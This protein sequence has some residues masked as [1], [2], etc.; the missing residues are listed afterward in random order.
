MP[1]KG[2][3]AGGGGKP[4]GKPA[5]PKMK[6]VYWDVLKDTSGTIWE[7]KK[8]AADDIAVQELF[9]DLEAEF[10][11]KPPAAKKKAAKVESSKP[12]VVSLIDGQKAQNMSISLARYPPREKLADML[13]EFDE[14]GLGLDVI[15]GLLSFV[16]DASELQAVKAY[17]ESGQDVNVRARARAEL[18]LD[19]G[20]RTAS[21]FPRQTAGPSYF[22]A[23][24]YA[25]PSHRWH[26]AAPGPSGEVCARDAARAQAGCALARPAVQVPV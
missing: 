6:G 18:P 13:L 1:G 26:R 17:K 11:T 16:P 21:A 14:Q 12:K 4:G 9:P 10:V 7:E 23:H 20:R 15:Q 5:G 19:C 24:P 3:G 2:P 8:D 22:P 25:V